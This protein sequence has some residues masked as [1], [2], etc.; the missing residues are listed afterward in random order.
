MFK[1]SKIGSW[2][3]FFD[4]LRETVGTVL[5]S[6]VMQSIQMFYGGPVMSF[7]TYFERNFVDFR[8]KER[9]LVW[10]L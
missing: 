4:I 6:I 2:K 9:I 3:F 7:V 8:K 10:T 5:C 1:I